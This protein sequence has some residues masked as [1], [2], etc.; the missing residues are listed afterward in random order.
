[1]ESRPSPPAA[2]DDQTSSSTPESLS[3]GGEI[4]SGE[5]ATVPVAESLSSEVVEAD[6][7]PQ[8]P[9]SA[10]HVKALA[11][12]PSRRS[13]I[14]AGGG[15]VA[16]ALVALAIAVPIGVGTASE[17]NSTASDLV[18]ITGELDRT[19]STLESVQDYN[20]ELLDEGEGRRAELDELE[21]AIAARE[22]AV[23]DREAAVQVLED[24]IAANSFGTGTYQ[25]GVDITA[26][27]YRND[28]S[29]RCYWERLSNGGGGFDAI[30]ANDNVTGQAIVTI[31]ESDWGFSSS[32]CGT[33]TKQ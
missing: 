23:G 19:K 7:S 17:L 6:D 30:I 25:V 1:M 3:S 31:S 10:D 26:G 28:G 18:G 29:D 16:G 27:T 33:W 32:R 8:T 21:A 4:T 22:A 15:F 11:C 24:T 14:L 20:R 2:D 12:M 9:R 5:Q 13:I